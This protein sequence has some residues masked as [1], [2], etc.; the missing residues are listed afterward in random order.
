MCVP[1]WL[2]QQFEISLSPA[3]TVSV[4]LICRGSPL[5]NGTCGCSTVTL[6]NTMAWLLEYG[7]EESKVKKSSVP[8]QTQGAQLL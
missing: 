8:I 6:E 7:A 2:S 1:A 4:Y 5:R 3:G